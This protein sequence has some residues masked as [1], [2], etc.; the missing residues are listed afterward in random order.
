MVLV[1]RMIQIKKVGDEEVDS[2]IGIN[3]DGDGGSG[4]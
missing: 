3:G 4:G 2:G 1:G